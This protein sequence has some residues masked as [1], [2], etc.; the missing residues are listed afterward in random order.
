MS[1]TT[2]TAK[3]PRAHLTHEQY[4]LLREWTANNTD[5]ITDLSNAEHADRAGETLGFD[6]STSTIRD[7][8][9]ILGIT[10]P[11]PEKQL[12]PTELLTLVTGLAEVVASMQVRIALLEQAP[13]P[14]PG[15]REATVR[16]L[17]GPP[18]PHPEP[19]LSLD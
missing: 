11:D 10:R 1:D 9:Q 19:S 7:L 6:V 4:Y 2:T 12:E 3:K 18:E 16:E 14:A 15:I 5:L 8:R 17:F 13:D